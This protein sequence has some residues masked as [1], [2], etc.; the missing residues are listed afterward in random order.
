M[1][2]E[3]AITIAREWVERHGSCTPNFVGAYLVGGILSLPP[4]APFPSYR[5]VDVMLVLDGTPNQEGGDI[6]YNGLIIGC[7]VSS[8]DA[9]RA[10]EGILADPGFAGNL[11]PD[12]MVLADPQGLLAP[13]H[14]TVARE[15]GRR[16][17]VA[18]RCAAEKRM[19]VENVETVARAVAT[20]RTIVQEDDESLYH[21][22][23]WA[24]SSVVLFL[25][26]LVAV[27]SLR[28]PTYRRSYVLL[29]ELLHE[30][31][32]ADLHEE[33]LRL[34]GYEHISRDLAEAYLD[35]CADAFDTAAAVV[36]RTVPFGYSL[37]P[38]VRPYVIEG[39]HEMIEE[40]YHREAMFWIASYLMITAHAIGRC[41]PVAEA[42]R[43][44]AAVARLNRDAGLTD[45]DTVRAR[46]AMAQRLNA[47]M[48]A[49]TDHIV[50]GLPE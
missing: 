19:I 18:A 27:A 30:H 37:R 4:S 1:N 12:A 49:V 23:L 48:F 17:W 40:G 42:S 24:L 21:Q 9:Y 47:E 33:A 50:E 44:Q 10:P 8:A 43:Y 7:G 31:G 20:S 38:H 45:H 11:G 13:L 3:Q 35:D 14:A 32:R 41:A 5:D 34:P 15:Y 46:L 6:A 26:G 36:D 16:C 2:V 39:A 28:R 25:S 22:P 29:S